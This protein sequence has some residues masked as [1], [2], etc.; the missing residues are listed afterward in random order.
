VGFIVA[1]GDG[2]D[3]VLI[4]DVGNAVRVSTTA[5]CRTLSKGVQA[6]IKKQA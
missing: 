5:V 2:V 6:A 1:V 4:V 3:E